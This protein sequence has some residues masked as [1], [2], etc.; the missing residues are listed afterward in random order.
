MIL[1]LIFGYST[2]THAHFC[3]DAAETFWVG[4]MR[5]VARNDP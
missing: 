3:V 5:D 1:S 4:S 2:P